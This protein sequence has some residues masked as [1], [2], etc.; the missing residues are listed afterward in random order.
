M[1]NFIIT[2]IFFGLIGFNSQAQTASFSR[3]DFQK[4]DKLLGI[5]KTEKKNGMLY[6]AW[7]KNGD[8]ELEGKSF[9]IVSGD[10]TIL[11][12]VRL[13]LEED[14]RIVYAVRVDGQ[15]NNRETLFYLKIVTGSDYIFENLQH[16]FPKRIVYNISN[17]NSLH[18]YIEGEIEGK[19]QRVDFDYIRVPLEIK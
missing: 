6:E 7:R 8:M 4:F 2:L 15:N 17:K 10:T 9:K 18:A 5:W 3:K 11:E 13:A 19:N 16:D 14:S 1:A 12:K